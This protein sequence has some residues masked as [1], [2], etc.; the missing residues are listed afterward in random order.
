MFLEGDDKTI[1]SERKKGCKINM[2]CH[3]MVFTLKIFHF[4]DELIDQFRFSHIAD[5]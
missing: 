1:G 5:V 3:K 2:N 4:R